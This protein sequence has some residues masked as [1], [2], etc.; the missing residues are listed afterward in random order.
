M[1]CFN[2]KHTKCNT[3]L[4][5]W[6]GKTNGSCSSSDSL[7][8]PPPNSNSSVR[9]LQISSVVTCHRIQWCDSFGIVSTHSPIDP[10][11]WNNKLTRPMSRFW[12]NKHM[13]CLFAMSVFEFGPKQTRYFDEPKYQL[14]HPCLRVEEQS[15]ESDLWRIVSDWFPTIITEH[16]VSADG[17]IVSADVAP[18][19]SILE[20]FLEVWE[21]GCARS[22][23]IPHV[24]RHHHRYGNIKL[25]H[26][27]SSSWRN[28]RCWRDKLPACKFVEFGN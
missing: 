17:A 24:V 9:Q 3:I 2:K 8:H 11:C 20:V 14:P 16:T 6:S 19:S 27:P 28:S 10:S 12:I 4:N 21:Q 26:R 15:F 22:A 5:R 7:W 1:T 13:Y 18:R 25:R 23:Q